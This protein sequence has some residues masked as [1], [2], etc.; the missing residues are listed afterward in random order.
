MWQSGNLTNHAN[1]LTVLKPFLLSSNVAFTCLADTNTDTI[2]DSADIG[3]VANVNLS[4]VIYFHSTGLDATK[5]IYYCF[6]SVSNAV[7]GYYNIGMRVMTSF[8]PL[9]KK[10]LQAG[11]SPPHYICMTNTT[12]PYWFIANAQCVK[13]LVSSQS[14]TYRDSSYSGFFT[15]AIS[16]AGE[17]PLPYA[18]GGSA[19]DSNQLFN[20]TTERRAFFT[21]YGAG[22]AI[23]ADVTANGDHTLSVRAVGGQWL[24]FGNDASLSDTSK[25]S[26]YTEPYI[27]CG[28]GA[29]ATHPDKVY[30]S[31]PIEK[32]P[33]P[34][35]LVSKLN[36]YK[37]TYGELDGVYHISG[38]G[39][40]P[41][42][43]IQVSGVDYLVWNSVNQAG[44]TMFAAFKLE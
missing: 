35:S 16:A 18:I 32:V 15:P 19:T 11:V 27:N 37:G 20:D 36:G 10:H 28:A 34:I 31:S 23:S 9:L 41:E 26:L 39:L 4:R 44:R 14:G 33:R 17:F 29:V 3:T 38:E 6:W 25:T 21:P 42:D 7:T 2:A 8:N 30:G 12:T 5:N 1:F 24:K 13:C 43:I 22:N 40:S